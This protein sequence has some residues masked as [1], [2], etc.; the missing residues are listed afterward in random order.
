MLS[1]R[2]AATDDPA[3]AQL[4][5]PGAAAGVPTRSPALVAERDGAAVGYCVLHPMR[6][7]DPATRP[8]TEPVVRVEPL[9]VSAQATGVQRALLSA[10][11]RLAAQLG[12]TRIV[13][14]GQHPGIEVAGY[15]RGPDGYEKA[16][17]GAN[18]PP[19]CAD[20]PGRRT[21]AGLS[22]PRGMVRPWT[23]TDTARPAAPIACSSSRTARTAMA[24]TAPSAA[25]RAAA[26]RSWSTH[27]GPLRG[28]SPAAR[29]LP[30]ATPAPRPA[31]DE[32][33]PAQGRV[34]PHHPS[35]HERA[36]FAG[37]RSTSRRQAQRSAD[38]AWRR[39][40]AG[41]T[42]GRAAG[43]GAVGTVALTTCRGRRS[44]RYSWPWTLRVPV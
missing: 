43:A 44:D 28:G 19:R 10:A 32:K 21:C 20:T 35:R 25:A 30:D 14:P 37:K 29:W 1:V 26:R 31:R 17:A 38:R 15:R 39:R 3:L 22:A 23:S 41:A 18:S 7:R 40:G 24:P 33:R 2:P 13:L 9:V 12:A 16:L 42:K 11:E 4:A 8:P 5:T 27:H 36:S 34:S 6:G